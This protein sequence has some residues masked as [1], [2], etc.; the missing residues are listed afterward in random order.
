MDVD[1]RIHHSLSV[2]GWAGQVGTGGG[3]VV[4]RNVLQ[5]TWGE[6]G[7]RV[8]VEEDRTRCARVL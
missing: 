1:K 6:E 2:G 5:Q 4:W 8:G 3:E 7:T